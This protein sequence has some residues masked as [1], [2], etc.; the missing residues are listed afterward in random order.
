[1]PEGQQA[2]K[3]KLTAIL[4]ADVAGYS[5][6]TQLDEEGTHLRLSSYLDL[7][8]ET[9]KAY[10]GAVHHFAGDAILADF[11]TVAAAICCAVRVQDLLAE[12]NR[13]LDPDHRVEF[14]IGVNLGDVILDRN[15]IYGDGV[16]VAARIQSLA[17]PGEICISGAAREAVGDSLPLQ[18][19]DAGEKRVKNIA[20]PVRVFRVLWEPGALPLPKPVETT[21]GKSRRPRLILLAGA[22]MAVV[23][24]LAALLLEAPVP[25]RQPAP[26]TTAAPIVQQQPTRPGILVLPFANRSEDPSQDYFGDG[27]AEDL[28]VDLARNPEL[29]V[30]SSRT[31]LG[32]RDTG[33]SLRQVA[34]ELAVTYV[35][36][37]SVRQAGENLRINVQLVD[38]DSD[39]T[40]WAQRFD[41]PAAEIFHIQ[42]EVRTRILQSLANQLG[43]T[44]P[45]PSANPHR[46]TASPAAYDRLLR[47]LHEFRTF[48][49]EGNFAARRYFREAIELDPGYARAY[50]DVALS[51][52]VA[53]QFGW[54]SDQRRALTEG[55]EYGYKGMALDD[56]VREVP[57]AM[58]SVLQIN[59][60][61]EPSIALARRAVELVP[62]YA[63][64]YAQLAQTLSYAGHQGEAL[65]QIQ[66]ALELNPF[67]PVFY[68]FI[69]GHIDL[70]A[71]RYEEAIIASR[72]AVDN[73][74]EFLL[75]RLVLASAYAHAGMMEEAEW[76][77]ME[78]RLQRPD[79]T[80]GTERQWRRY[81]LDR[82]LEHY[83]RGLRLAGLPS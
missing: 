76:E 65:E 19:E 51:L 46:T 47:G 41:R 39:Q 63:D 10:G 5:R 58:S 61:F 60:D 40:L 13:H 54:V 73:N 30:V 71:R 7:F 52:S 9:V 48:T 78:I 2:L 75:A 21:K 74:P 22:A 69:R 1:M 55:L 6:L 17:G 50:A 70:C 24:M 37:G 36:E 64:G 80:V 57:F 26:V 34:T 42:D 27:I 56:T 81:G 32:Y 45:E 16:N 72:R 66:R 59:G 8:A 53:V 83:L 33:M 49:R 31:A 62:A 23:V 11:P 79:H 77:V 35:L 20:R 43:I 44:L 68:A 15:E 12:R 38:A 3:R 29:R 25:S 18:M 67:E 28:I 82:D 14:R 4:Y